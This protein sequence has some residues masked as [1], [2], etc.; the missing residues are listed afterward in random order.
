MTPEERQQ[1]LDGI[2]GKPHKP[3]SGGKPWQPRHGL[4]ITGACLMAVVWLYKCWE[5]VASVGPNDGWFGLALATLI[6][7]LV[8]WYCVWE[9]KESIKDAARERHGDEEDGSLGLRRSEEEEEQQAREPEKVYEEE[10]RTYEEEE[11]I[12]EEERERI[13]EQEMMSDEEMQRL[14]E[15]AMYEDE[16]R[17]IEQER[18][19]EEDDV[20]E[21]YFDNFPTDRK[22]DWD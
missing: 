5:F 15:D 8:G 9:I 16:E 1:W 17:R 13:L 7:G 4:I 20:R 22:E 14:E 3:Q 10:E 2:A 21:D 6:F 11:R 18:M 19:A 12:L